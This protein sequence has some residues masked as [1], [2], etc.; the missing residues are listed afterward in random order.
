MTT[1][2][3]A[4]HCKLCNERHW[5]TEPHKYPKDLKPRPEIKGFFSR[6]QIVQ[7][8]PMANP[9]VPKRKVSVTR[10]RVSVTA[11]AMTKPHPT[12]CANCG[13]IFIPKRKTGRFCS[14]TCRVQ[15]NRKSAD[16]GNR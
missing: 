10:D 6:P 16:A 9:G 13:N 2:I 3:K 14:S 1:G 11:T 12:P 8:Q 15:A 5:S 4:P 7:S